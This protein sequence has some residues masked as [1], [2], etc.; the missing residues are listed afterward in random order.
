MLVNSWVAE[1]LEASQ[2]G[3]SIMGFVAWLNYYVCCAYILQYVNLSWCLA[4]P[5]NLTPLCGIVFTSSILTRSCSGALPTEAPGS[6]LCGV[7]ADTPSRAYRILL[8][9]HVFCDSAHK[10][11]KMMLNWTQ[12]VVWLLLFN[13]WQ[14]SS[15]KWKPSEMHM[16]TCWLFSIYCWYLH[17]VCSEYESQVGRHALFQEYR[18]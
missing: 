14:R 15:C 5:F 17:C 1:Q 16:Y 12:Q 6:R 11:N 18:T 3:L 13:S 8:I 10:G 9:S 7:V 4:K 2:E